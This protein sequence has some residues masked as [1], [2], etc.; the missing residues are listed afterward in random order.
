MEIRASTVLPARREPIELVTADGL[1]LVGELALPADRPPA[2]TLVCLHPLPTHGGMMDSHVHKKA[3]NRLPALADLAVLRFNTRGTTS[4]RGTSQG[5]FGN[6]EDERLDVAAALEYAEFHDLPR[7]W[8]VGWSFG[9]ELALKWGRDPL[10]EGAIL[11]SPPLHRAT[12]ADLDGWAEFGR[13]LT[14][15][16]PEFDDYL[17]PAEARE[18]FARVPQ[19]EVVGVD[20]AKHLW[21]GEPYVRIVLNEIVRRVNPAAYPLPTEIPE[22]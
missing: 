2:A 10:V 15:L 17:R 3:A 13:P 21:V 22:P 11:L 5:A 18:R 8:L 12:D 6:G 1:T 19:A 20:G 4:D 7:A 16:V 14:A 9:T